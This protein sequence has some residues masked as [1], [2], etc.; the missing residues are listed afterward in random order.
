MPPDKLEERVIEL[1]CELRMPDRESR[2]KRVVM[3]VKLG[4]EMYGDGGGMGCG[5][6]GEGGP[7]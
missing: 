1:A 7:G 5:V 6:E 3:N 2:G 4:C